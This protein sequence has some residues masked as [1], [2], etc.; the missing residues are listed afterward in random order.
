MFLG[1]SQ[2]DNDLLAKVVDTL[3]GSA[4]HMCPKCDVSL[5]ETYSA[6]K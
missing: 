1:V 6:I 2:F 5:C 4:T 3:G